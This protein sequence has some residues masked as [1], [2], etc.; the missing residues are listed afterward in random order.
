MI[1]VLPDSVGN[2]LV[3]K[4]AGKL[5][6]AVYKDVLIP[7]VKSAIRDHGKTR[8]LVGV[9]DDF[10]GWEVAAFWDDARIGITHRRDFEKLGVIGGSKWMEWGVKLATLIV[11]GEIRS[12]PAGER[13][14]A[15]KWIRA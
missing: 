3:L 14:E 7:R 11:C 1:E 2:I 4:T 10:H 15:L 6:D 8:I 13:G 12:F 5:T 9:G